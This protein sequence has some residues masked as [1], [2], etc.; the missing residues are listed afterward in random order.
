MSSTQGRDSFE[1][2]FLIVETR[3]RVV[4]SRQYRLRNGLVQDTLNIA[5]TETREA[6]PREV[7]FY[8]RL[9]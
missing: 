4:E 3:A 2:A 7:V 1:V 9:G 6:F 8:R 5:K